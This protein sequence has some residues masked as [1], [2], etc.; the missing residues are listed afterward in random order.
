MAQMQREENVTL[1]E[2]PSGVVCYELPLF[3]A[4]DYGR[5][6]Q[7][8]RTLLASTLDGV[9]QSDRSHE[10]LEE[11]T[12]RDTPYRRPNT[13]LTPESVSA[14]VADLLERDDTEG[15]TRFV[16]LFGTKAGTAVD[17]IEREPMDAVREF[18]QERG[19]VQICAIQLGDSPTDFI[20][21]PHERT[22]SID[23]QLLN[24]GIQG[25]SAYPTRPYHKLYSASLESLFRVPSP[26]L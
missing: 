26:A 12:N 23:D 13:L 2:R 18:S 15:C 21:V 9:W 7:F 11:P 8:A 22:R 5:A 25:D 16:A 14:L 4:L 3:S 20:F 1:Y 6:G 24:W 10:G 17:L 19:V